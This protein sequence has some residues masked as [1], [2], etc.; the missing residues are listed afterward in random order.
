MLCDMHRG[1]LASLAPVPKKLVLAARHLV[2]QADSNHRSGLWLDTFTY[3]VESLT[4]A[5]GQLRATARLHGLHETGHRIIEAI[6]V[7][8]NIAP[9]F[10]KVRPDGADIS[11]KTKTAV[12]QLEAASTA[13]AESLADLLCAV[14]YALDRV[15]QVGNSAPLESCP[16]DSTPNSE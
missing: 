9:A 2:E 14:E 13:I 10:A 15:N 8:E 6:E 3:Y 11:D 12:G 16:Q 7:L 4:N 1:L 5:R